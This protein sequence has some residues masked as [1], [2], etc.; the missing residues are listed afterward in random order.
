MKQ[1]L[2]N[3]LIEK[4]LKNGEK[5]SNIKIFEDSK[6]SI[7]YAELLKISFSNINKIKLIKDDYIPILVDRN[8]NSIIAILSIILSKKTFCP[9]S[10]SLPNKR[11]NKITQILNSKHIINCSQKKLSELS[12]LKEIKLNKI[13]SVKKF[14]KIKIN[15][16]EKF[17]N[18]NDI[19]YILF[20]SGS[21]GSPKGVKL[22]YANIHNTLLWSRKYLRWKNHKIGIAT[23]LSFD[24]S[25]FDVFS[26]LFFNVPSFL[27]SNPS[28]PFISQKEINKFKVTSIFSVPA[29][30]SN[31]I[32]FDLLKNKNKLKRIISGGDFFPPKDILYWKKNTLSEV[33]NVWGPTETS[34]VNSMY[35]I[36]KKDIKNLQLGKNQPVGKSHKEMEINIV[37]NRKILKR[38]QIGEICMSGK[39]VAAG[40]LGHIKNQRNF[41]NL[42]GKK[43]Y[44]TGDVGYFDKK[45]NLFILGRKDNTIKIL[46]YRVDALEI[47]NTVNKIDYITSS[48]A[49]VLEDYGH[50]TLCLAIETKKAISIERIKKILIQNLPKYSIPKKIKFFDK[51]PI[52]FNYKIDQ[53]KIKSAFN[54]K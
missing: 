48:L 34:I 30:F 12:T 28:D 46:G 39:C 4:I 52:N 54:E 25:M 42:K 23:Q 32:K 21:T 50:K 36:Q 44:L 18:F 10:P 11:I 13:N 38:K 49:F 20:T 7:T 47:Q 1:K 3:L 16:S 26:G 33:F 6:N 53:K 27:F 35:K 15:F 31:F 37:K 41:I 17:N 40:Y 14:R 29:F 51:F 9:I 2:K 24:I 43:S 19:F 45:G 22:S 5:Y 8:L